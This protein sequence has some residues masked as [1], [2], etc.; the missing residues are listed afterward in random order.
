MNEVDDEYFILGIFVDEMMGS[1]EECLLKK[2]RNVAPP[3]NQIRRD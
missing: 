3:S 1:D 2:S